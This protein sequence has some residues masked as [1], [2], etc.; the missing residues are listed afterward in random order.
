M[1]ASNPLPLMKYIYVFKE[2]M[3]GKF[4]GVNLMSQA[5]STLGCLAV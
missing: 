5:L 3:K 4:F 2:T 1:V